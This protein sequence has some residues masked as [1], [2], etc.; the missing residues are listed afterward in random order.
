MAKAKRVFE[1]AKELGV[2][3]KAIVDKC[4]AEGVPGI[5]NHMS[6][7]KI[8]LVQTIHEWFS[9]AQ[10]H[11]AIES[12]DKVDLDKVRKRRRRP[13][14]G[15]GEHSDEPTDHAE[16]SVATAV[17]SMPAP[18][19]KDEVAR[20]DAG[21]G[22]EEPP[23]TEVV[24][25]AQVQAPEDVPASPVDHQP[26][27]EPP[28]VKPETQPVAEAGA[29]AHAPAAH[30]HAAPPPA[31]DAGKSRG[32]VG[33][34]NVPLRPHVVKPMG[35]QLNKPKEAVL[36][37]P[38]VVRIEKPDEVAAPRP[39]RS[40]GAGSSGGGGQTFDSDAGAGRPRGPA[41]GRG[42]TGKDTGQ[43]ADGGRAPAKRR[44]L[45][46]RR[47]RSAE[48][49]PTGP[50][51]FS[52]QD[53]LEL[54]ARLR[55]AAGFLKQ[56][57]RD[58]KKHE[59]NNPQAL[60]SPAV[61]GGKVE[62]QEPI[63]I[64]NLS[65]VTGIK[66]ADIIKY[67]FKK[68]VMATINSAIDAETAV[69][70]ALEYDIELVVRGQQT[71]EQAVID[72][73]DSR[74]EIDVR[75]RPPVVAV[76][77]HVD[78]GKTSLLD[79]IRQADVAAHEAGG[80]T[81]HVG[82]YRV[83]ITGHEGRQKTVVFLDTPGHEAFTHMRARGANMTDIVVLVVA[84]DDGVMPQTVESINHA[85]A[86]GV[87]IVVALNKIDRPDASTENIRRIYGQ[88]AE[89]GL[90][91]VEWGGQTEIV[92][93][94]AIAGTGITELLEMLDYQ[95]E[96]LELKADYGG[97]ARGL[98]IEAQ[99][100]EGRGPVAR[101]L[102]QQGQI[103]VGDFI[104]M[105]RAFGRVRDM[106]DDRGKAIR[107]AGPATPLELSGIDM[108]PDAGDKFY[109]TDSLQRAEQ[110]SSQ[111][112]EIERTRQLASKTKI[113]LDN[114]ADQLKAGRSKELRLVI[115]AD[116]QG[117]VE[118]LRDTLAKIGTA[119][120]SVRVLH[121][122]VG[123]INESDVL[124]ADASDAV[125]VGFHVVASSHAR[126]LAEQMGVD[127][128]LYRII[129]ELVDEVTK[130]LEGMLAPEARE[131]A[132][133]QAE[134]REVFKITKLGSV[135]GCLVVEGLIRRGGKIRVVRDNVVVTDN[136]DIESLRR[137]KDDVR[138]V[139]L[140]TECGI[141]IAGFDDV[142]PGDRLHCYQTV[143]VRRTLG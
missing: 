71:A 18:T 67:L 103:K 4:Q 5:T 31:E 59:S 99:M 139:R 90:N 138:E 94:S 1:V 54:D 34:P 37:G 9:A 62:I 85:K 83:T 39:R 51:K 105:G 88:L 131:E 109:V 132:I 135:A 70:V 113:T 128:R 8:G 69:E 98:V 134:V 119:E 143:Q 86:A 6:T 53:L 44:S 20:P 13:G 36:K 50:T 116:V 72:D 81:Q 118:V 3:S 58:L 2:S 64:K 65:S 60:Q 40:S 92:R 57:R 120:V 110:I 56:R 80:I 102:V 26:A 84:A 95:A 28:S 32:P 41:R 29:T 96:L 17:E 108:V 141:R 106:S 136:R 46:S 24:A 16:D 121:A 52:E 123:G 79:R 68:G 61:A 127:I 30:R 78:H 142:K 11:T 107:L 82:A 43:D 23:P 129:Y 21:E 76:L 87:P 38:R 117:S 45:T 126:D 114:F 115:K 12:A 77:G 63:F 74:Q 112:R 101:V 125:I 19:A 89:Q 104:V 7:V 33:R 140:G 122:A 35:Q 14:A 49:L 25:G 97:T 93:T 124:L 10:T 27:V 66:V 111:Y 47:G 73:F 48:A 42:A 22:D 75:P 130:S 91:P 100:Q 137:V 55:G 133:G 15:E